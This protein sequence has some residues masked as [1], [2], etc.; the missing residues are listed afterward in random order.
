MSNEYSTLSRKCKQ[1][2]NIHKALKIAC[3]LVVLM[4]CFSPSEAQIPPSNPNKTDA[5]GLRQGPWTIWFNAQ[6][7]VTSHTDSIAYYR[8]INYQDNLP[9]DTVRDYYTSGA[10]QMKGIMINDRPEEKLHGKIRFFAENGHLTGDGLYDSGEW[11][12]RHAYDSLGKI[13]P[14]THVNNA[15]NLRKKGMDSLAIHYFQ[16]ARPFVLNNYQPDLIAVFYS[17]Y[18]LSFEALNQSDSAI[19]MFKKSI[20]YYESLPPKKLTPSYVTLLRKLATHHKSLDQFQEELPYR[21]KIVRYEDPQRVESFLLSQNNLAVVYIHTKAYSKAQRLYRKIEEG[22]INQFGKYSKQYVIFLNNVALV[23]L[24]IKDNQKALEYTY[25][26]YSLSKQVEDMGPE[27]EALPANNLGYILSHN[28]RLDSAIYYYEEVMQIIAPLPFAKQF[29]W[30]LSYADD[31]SEGRYVTQSLAKYK[32]LI[33]DIQQA[34][35]SN[36]FYMAKTLQHYGDALFDVAKY[37]SAIQCFEQ[38]IDAHRKINDTSSK[39][40]ANNFMQLGNAYKR[41]QMYDSSIFYYKRVIQNPG[42]LSASFVNKFR[43]GYANA[44]EESGQY[45]A[46][47]KECK[48]LL[49]NSAVKKFPYLYQQIKNTLANCYSHTR[50]LHSYARLTHENL[51]NMQM[52][53]DTLKSLFVNSLSG[54]G[55]YY[56]HMGDYAKSYSYYLRAKSIIASINGKKSYE[57]AVIIRNIASLESSIG[58]YARSEELLRQSVGICRNLEN[59]ETYIYTHIMGLLVSALYKQEKYE[60]AWQLASDVLKKSIALLGENDSRLS[61]PYQH[62]AQSY[63]GL[64]SLTQARDAYLKAYELS[65]N[66]YGLD[67]LNFGTALGWIEEKLGNK[68]QAIYYYNQAIDNALN[69]N[70]TNDNPSVVNLRY[71]K[72]K[73]LLEDNFGA[74]IAEM[75]Q[76]YED[77]MEPLLNNYATLTKEQ[78]SHYSKSQTFR[79][80]YYLWLKMDQSRHDKQKT[81]ELYK[82]QIDTKGL[83][84]NSVSKMVQAILSSNDEQLIANYEQWKA[85]SQLSVEQSTD[86]IETVAQNLEKKLIASTETFKDALDVSWK[87]VKKALKKGEAALEIVRLQWPA[88]D[89]VIYFALAVKHNSTAPELI[90]YPKGKDLEEKHLKYYRNAIRF[91]VKDEQSYQVYWKPLE[92]ALEGVKK[93]YVSAD[94]VFH[95]ISLTT[96][97]K[98]ESEHYLLDD[99]EI[100]YV[101]NTKE[102]ARPTVPP[103]NDGTVHLFGYPDYQSDSTEIDL[104]GDYYARLYEETVRFFDGNRKITNLPGTRREVE[105]IN[106]I[107][108][109]FQHPGKLYLY[110]DATESALKSIKSPRILHIAT[111]GFFLED[112]DLNSMDD[113]NVTGNAADQVAEDPLLRSGLLLTNAQKALVEG[114]DGVFMAKE[115]STINLEGTELVVLSACE[116]G[117]G[118]IINGGGVYGLQYALQNAGARKVLMSLWKVDDT[119]TQKLLTSFYTYLLGDQLSPEQAFLKAQQELRSTYPSPYYWGAFK[120]IGK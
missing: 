108:Q 98:P 89:S 58:N 99:M 80:G 33:E 20:E 119:A 84:Y 32:Q 48:A 13:N 81:K 42:V 102:I 101:H 5:D 104:D 71:F 113:I 11:V 109:N 79:I 19:W 74:G 77:V 92:K 36:N 27:D 3:L 53:H 88:R 66:S 62:L 83:Q 51:A 65:R 31:L 10:L 23:Y 75:D 82:T 46:A 64:D 95:S 93:V 116:T 2:F 12:V 103:R 85:L 40:Y 50:D 63:A 90:L 22:Y 17:L 110:K 30:K 112:Q 106:Q 118:K 59:R 45:V 28:N 68:K 4:R 39:T 29:Q 9:V 44:L 16:R 114:G 91:K 86:S 55:S 15:L 73:L 117:L 56:N 38:A 35:G 1:H 111:H 107:L 105:A 72:A 115:A 47:I 94:G 70:L 6:W 7:K 8:L 25:R 87:N 37:D 120:M 78:R 34:E 43:M 97:K 52:H 41:K 69:A 67:A 26:S 21:E 18:G 49:R 60:E 24:R 61:G 100:H 76:L 57:M 14:Q 96:L 54:M